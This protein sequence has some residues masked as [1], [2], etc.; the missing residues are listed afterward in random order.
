MKSNTLSAL[1]IEA[2]KENREF[3]ALVNRI[4]ADAEVS[5]KAYVESAKVDL[6]GE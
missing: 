2:P 6:G 3:E 1:V 5:A 4:Q